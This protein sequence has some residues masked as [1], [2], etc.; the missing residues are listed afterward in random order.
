MD[1]FAYQVHDIIKDYRNHDGIHLSTSD[2]IDWANQFNEDAEFILRELSIILPQVYISRDEAKKFV[3]RRIEFYLKLYRYG[4]ISTF[5]SE[6]EFLNM[7]LPFKSQPAILNLL[8]EVLAEYFEESYFKY[9][10]FPKINYVYFDDILASG[11]TIGNHL[12]QWLNSTDEQGKSNYEKVA[13]SEIRLAV[14]L[15]CYHS[16]GLSFQ[17]FRINKTFDE[18]LGNKIHWFG[19]YEIQNHAKFFNQ[20]LNIVKPLKGSDL[21]VNTYF[22]SLNATKYEDYAFREPYT[23]TKETFFSNAENRIRFENIILNKGIEIINMIQGPIKTNI[24]P[25]GLINPSYKILGLGTHFFT[26]RNIPNNCPLVY[27]WEVNGHNWKPLF[28]VVNRGI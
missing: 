25:L 11:S 28:P 23:P 18:K 10:T 12:V 19:D 26:W 21:L 7:Q 5:L 13:S 3:K 17:K 6:T 9:V 16:W 15:L 4:S 14:S 8:E 20:R 22:A 2:I 24:R 1:E 27:W